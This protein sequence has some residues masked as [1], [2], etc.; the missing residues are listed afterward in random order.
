M[1]KYHENRLKRIIDDTHDKL[2]SVLFAMCGEVHLCEDIMQE[3]YIRLWQHIDNVKDDHAI[4]AL[5]RQYARNIFLDEM[6][7]RGRQKELLLKVTREDMAPSPD[8]KVMNEEKHQLI[9]QAINKLPQQQQLI[10]RMH[11]EHDMSYRQ[12]AAE[13][14]IATGTIEKQMNRALR[15]LKHE[16]I[17]LK[18]MDAGIIIY[19]TLLGWQA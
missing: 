13:L 7:K 9:Q 11:K 6:R 2:F 18:R 5:L 19:I 1:Q 12:I 4:L 10:F 16:L 14:E 3:C 8:E 15:S 17:H